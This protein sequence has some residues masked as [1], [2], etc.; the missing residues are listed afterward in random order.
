MEQ[1]L[2]TLVDGLPTFSP[3]AKTI[4]AFK[5]LVTRDKGSKG[6]H[7]GRKK[8]QATKELAYVWFIS[9]PKSEF[10]NNYPE[11]DRDPM[12]RKH[13]GLN[14]W[15]ADAH[16]QI[17]IDTFREITETQSSKLLQ[18]TKDSLFSSQKIVNL[19]RKKMEAKLLQVENSEE[20]I[21]SLGEMI[22]GINN[23]FDR[24]LN[25]STKIPT[26][27]STIEKLEERVNKERA[28]GKGRGGKEVNKFQFPRSKR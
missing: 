27:L 26:L 17:A 3:Y 10:V 1:E 16:V 15:Q 2:V 18:D 13:L 14:D 12:I 20:A 11:E 28:S 8:L 22:D 7:D 9:H 21:T 24:L 4:E 25:I 6:D 23:D 19:I 5:I